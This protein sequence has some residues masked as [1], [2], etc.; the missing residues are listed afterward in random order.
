MKHYQEQDYE[1]IDPV[2]D[3]IKK[4]KDIFTW[5]EINNTKSF[6]KKQKKILN[7]ARDAELF[8][9]VGFTLHGHGAALAGIG[10]ASTERNIDLHPIILNYARLLSIQF[11]TCFWALMRKESN[12]AT[13]TL[14][15]REQEVLKW[16]AKGYTQNDIAE[17]L[18]LSSHTVDGY[19]RVIKNKLDTKNI[20]ATVILAIKMGLINI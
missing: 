16:I 18:N 17:R 11:Y 13:I 4:G 15:L 12:L 20:T 5:D 1:K 14:S 10:A 9:G 3:W 7:E 19:I 8:Q 2:I 6:S